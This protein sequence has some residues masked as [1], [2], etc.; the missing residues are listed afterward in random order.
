MDQV[1]VESLGPVETLT[2]LVDYFQFWGALSVLILVLATALIAAFAVSFKRLFFFFVAI[3]LSVVALLM[4]YI[5]GGPLLLL[6]W[7]ALVI[8]CFFLLKIIPRTPVVVA[9]LVLGFGAMILGNVNHRQ[10]AAI[11]IDRSK[12][13]AAALET[14]KRAREQQKEQPETRPTLHSDINLGMEVSK[15]D[16]AELEKAATTQPD[17]EKVPEYKK[18]GK[19]KRSATQPGAVQTGAYAELAEPAGPPPR[20]MEANDVYRASRLSRVNLM[21][22]RVAF[23]IALTMVVFDYLSRF[24]RT[25]G[26]PLR[27]P[28]LTLRVGHVLVLAAAVFVLGRFVVGLVSWWNPPWM[29]W[30]DA[31]FWFGGVVGLGL[32]FIRPRAL[33]VSG[34]LVDS[35]FRKPKVTHVRASGREHLPDFLGVLARKGETFIYLGPEDP[36]P[37]TD[38][39]WRVDLPLVPPRGLPIKVG[40]LRKVLFRPEDAFPNESFLFETTWFRRYCFV[41]IGRDLGDRVLADIVER[42]RDRRASGAKASRTVN[43]VWD[44]AELSPGQLDELAWLCEE[45]NWKI[46]LWSAREPNRALDGLVEERFE[47]DATGEVRP[48]R[49]ATTAA[50]A[51][52]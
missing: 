17:E 11:Q 25:F 19:V 20:T 32:L 51:V 9:M 26:L 15:E 52:A 50:E 18:R 5:L 35:V 3:S 16:L 34:R 44:H 29:Q 7:V 4:L 14:Q 8:A 31:G 21:A 12:E 1:T 2:K 13:E 23:L 43:V 41:V 33:P 28:A 39:F 45:T 36:I 10:V 46:V 22:V 47:V 42:L 6:L 30:V 49:P 24:N 27:V 48:V 40:R 38:A 37:Q